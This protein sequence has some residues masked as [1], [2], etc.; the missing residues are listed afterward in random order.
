MLSHAPTGIS[1]YKLKLNTTNFKS[2]LILHFL[3]RSLS[4]HQ[5]KERHEMHFGAIEIQFKHKV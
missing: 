4:K 5:T 1:H 3:P 2:L